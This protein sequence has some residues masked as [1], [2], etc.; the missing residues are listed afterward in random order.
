MNFLDTLRTHGVKYHRS[1]TDRNEITICCP[2]CEF[3]GQTPD[4][5]FRLGV[6]ILTKVGH[7]FNC[8]WAS[9]KALQEISESL[10]LGFED[11]SEEGPALDHAPEKPALPEDYVLLT[12]PPSGRLY[13]NAVNYLRERGVAD[14]QIEQKFVGVSLIGR[15]AYRII[16][17]VY[18]RH[19]LEGLVTRDFT[20]KQEPPYLNSAN[21]KSL[22]NLPDD[23]CKKAVLCE[24]VFDC[25]AVERVV[26]NEY[27]VLAVLG[28]ALTER[29]EEQLE[30]YR[31]VILWPD[32]DLVGVKGFM[33]IANQLKARHRIFVVWPFGYDK[34]DAAAMYRRDRSL[35]WMSRERLTDSLEL[36]L[37]AEVVFKE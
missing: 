14:W 17:P 8:D 4:H 28:R 29:Q 9:G 5:R 35:A 1:N 6:N 36:R 22:Y 33:E 32:A 21:M 12:R 16:F 31:D 7:C 19:K 23:P 13:S 18:Y 26:S 34:K 24:G 30:P 2:F 11:L 27:N 37:K 20:G 25:L 15:Y 10:Q 3:R